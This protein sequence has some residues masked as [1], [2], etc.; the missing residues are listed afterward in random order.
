MLYE[1]WARGFPR[2]VTNGD[3]LGK[4]IVRYQAKYK[5]AL[6]FKQAIGSGLT[7]KELRQGMT[8][9][10]KLEKLCPFFSRLHHL[11]GER[12][13]VRPPA[14]TNVSIPGLPP[15]VMVT[16]AET[17]DDDDDSDASDAEEVV[18]INERQYLTTFSILGLPFANCLSFILS[19][20]TI[21]ICATVFT[22][23]ELPEF[24][25]V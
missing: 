3:N 8:M 25:S 6:T 24:N 15:A 20:S 5:E 11:Y 1:L 12:H 10:S 21:L 17:G 14:T 7:E 18:R 19:D 13:N 9:E 2:F 22:I 16:P 23:C 4:R